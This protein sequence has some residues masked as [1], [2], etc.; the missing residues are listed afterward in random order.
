MNDL[1]TKYINYFGEEKW[2]QEEMLEKVFPIQIEL[3]N[4]LNLEI[5]PVIVEDIKEESRYYIKEDYIAISN[6]ISKSFI[7]TVKAIVHECRHKYQYYSC[8]RGLNKNEKLIKEWQRD[9]NS[10]KEANLNDQQSINE[11]YTSV[12]ELDAFAFTKWY[13]KEKYNYDIVHLHSDYEEIICI[14]IEKYL[15]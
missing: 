1:K 3:C 6:K 5:P 12:L 15:K 4:Y 8:Y 13:L 9:F 2:N 10:I 14:Y 11:Y 7:E